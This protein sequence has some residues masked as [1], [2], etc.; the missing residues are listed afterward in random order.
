MPCLTP[1]AA[2]ERAYATRAVVGLV[3]GKCKDHLTVNR[4][5]ARALQKEAGLGG[6]SV[7]DLEA[8][9]RATRAIIDKMAGE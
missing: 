8:A 6:Q 7:P 2:I 1:A 9:S 5:R 4:E 3:E